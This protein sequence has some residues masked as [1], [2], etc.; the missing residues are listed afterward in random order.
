MLVIVR[1]QFIEDAEPASYRPEHEV[2]DFLGGYGGQK[3]G[4]YPFGEVIHRHDREPDT[5]LTIWKLTDE[6]YPPHR[7]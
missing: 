4:F 5:T 3:F 7:K 2:S 1:D 6:V